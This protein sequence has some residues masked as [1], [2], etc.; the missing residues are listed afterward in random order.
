MS[1]TRPRLARASAPVVAALLAL[2]LAACSDADIDNA[3]QQAKDAA[4]EARSAIDDLKA[5]VDEA[6]AEAD[7]AEQR[8]ADARAHPST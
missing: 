2:G 3:A 6:K 1:P 4:G 5:Q 8:I 7:A